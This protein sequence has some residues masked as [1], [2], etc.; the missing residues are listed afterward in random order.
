MS[1]CPRLFLFAFFLSTCLNEKHTIP[2]SL[3]LSSFRLRLSC[4]LLV[5][6]EMTLTKT[7]P[8]P[9]TRRNYTDKD[10]LPPYFYNKPI[11]DIPYP[12]HWR[13]WLSSISISFYLINIQLLTSFRK[14]LCY[15][16][17]YYIKIIRSSTLSGY[18]SLSSY[19]L[20]YNV[21]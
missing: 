3:F 14:F 10:Y 20:R 11:S 18:H 21:T 7:L 1:F 6:F 5:W 13:Q 2:L 8:T 16:I 15:I 9:Q 12:Y 17:S 19:C 4:F